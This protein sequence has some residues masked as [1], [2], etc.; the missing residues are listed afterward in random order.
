MGGAIEQ[1][2]AAHSNIFTGRFLGRHDWGRFRDFAASLT[3]DFEACQ[4][5]LSL[6]GRDFM[7]IR[8]SN[9]DH[10]RLCEAQPDVARTRRD[11]LD[12]E[13]VVTSHTYDFEDDR[14]DY[15]ETRIVTVG[16][17]RGRMMILVWTAR[18]EARHVISMRKA[19]EREQARYRI[20]LG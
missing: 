13:E 11:F 15:G 12:A 3:P 20:Y 16:V 9:E 18:G 6:L 17:R 19:N 2:P 8:N 10:I 5:G 1:P 14:F 7:Y 4:Q